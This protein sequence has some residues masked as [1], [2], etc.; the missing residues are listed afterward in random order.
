MTTVEFNAAI[1]MIP[2][3]TV[4]ELD[5]A[6]EYLYAMETRTFDHSRLMREISDELFRRSQQGA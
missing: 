1:E 4:A 3:M 5:A 2:A 6:W